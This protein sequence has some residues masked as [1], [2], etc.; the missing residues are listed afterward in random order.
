MTLEEG[1]SNPRD[2]FRG[3]LDLQASAIDHSAIF[4]CAN[5]TTFFGYMQILAYRSFCS[6][7]SL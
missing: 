3:L 2:L 4:P 5:G 6:L 1:D 7:K